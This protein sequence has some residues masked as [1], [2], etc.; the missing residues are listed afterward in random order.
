MMR[1]IIFSLCFFSVISAY[2]DVALNDNK[3][4]IQNVSK[5]ELYVLCSKKQ[6]TLILDRTE[7]ERSASAGW[8]TELAPF[9][10]SI[11]FTDNS[12]FIFSCSQES[13]GAWQAVDCSQ[14][15]LASRFPW[16]GALLSGDMPTGS[17]WV[18]E[19]IPSDDVSLVLRHRGFDV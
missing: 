6:T 19:N 15:I 3:I 2:A 17:Y 5:P 16:E 13:S 4:S 7:F 1:N 12:P 14:Y 8:S 11:F 10:C 18:A 9:A